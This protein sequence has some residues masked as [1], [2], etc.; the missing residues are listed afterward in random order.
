MKKLFFILVLF[1]ALTVDAA[2]YYVKVGGVDA[3]T[4]LSDAQAWSFTKLATFVPA[5]GDVIL[6]RR[7]DTFSGTLTLA[8]SATS[9]SPVTYGAYGSGAA[10][11]LSGFKTITGWTLYSTGIYRSATVIPT[12]C[13][14]V[15]INGT[16]TA[17]G[18]YPQNGF[19]TFESFTG[20]TS[21]VDNQLT[22]TPNFTG[23]EVVI[24]KS[25]W[26]IDRSPITSH[27]GTTV[28]YT[29]GS[30]YNPT[31]TGEYQYFFQKSIN[32][33]LKFGDWF[34]D[35]AYFYMFFGANNPASYVVKA[36]FEDKVIQSTS[37]H[38]NTVR[39]LVIE[40]G[41]TAGLYLTFSNGFKLINTTVKSI[42]LYGLW[43]SSSTTSLVDSCSFTDCNGWGANIQADGGVVRHST[44]NNI[45]LNFG[46]SATT[47][48]GH[49]A[50]YHKGVN[51]ITEYNVITN[52]GYIPL[53]FFGNGHQVRYNKVD[54]YALLGQHDGGGIY[55]YFG[56][57]G[58]YQSG[59][60]V[61]NNTVANSAA[62]GLYADN[63]SNNQ[64]WYN[65]VVVNITKWG[66][67]MNMPINNQIHN[68]VF[69]NCELAAIDV[70]NLA[71]QT[72]PASGTV[73][74]NN[75]IIQGNAAQ[76]IGSFN[77]DRTNQTKTVPFGT[78][79]QNTLIIDSLATNLY[80][81]RYVLPSYHTDSY[82][83][84]SWRTFSG[85]E[86]NS[87]IRLADV[88]ELIFLYNDTKTA[89]SFAITGAK[90]ELT[91]TVYQTTVTV[92]PFASILLFPHTLPP[93][94]VA[95]TKP[96][97]FGGQPL[98]LFNKMAAMP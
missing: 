56:V 92:Q 33:L 42:G 73:I 11:V 93:V 63:L 9:T 79:N 28:S 45:G 19:L 43:I 16:N 30:S 62:N 6:F 75:L 32:C 18:K 46:M 31:G 98:K 86:V 15:T 96:L 58:S 65:N 57:E 82:T 41:N 29:S 67:H 94:V 3:N 83:L 2:T 74:Q 78:S 34:T 61:Y 68:N 12:S 87:T 84:A 14:V 52:V 53:N 13:D 95:G 72:T 50:L 26:M 55:T 38:Y 24:R 23:A 88:A 81:N 85:R 51:N 89:K 54:T 22:N 7:G 66:M 59:M 20:R 27:S 1:A 39:D 80:Y 76:K 21:F 10:P 35:G 17:I 64:E 47:G 5:N 8:K 44:F 69:Y 97:R 4:G 60:K 37:K 36:G 48:G 77:D 91:G 49:T 70:S 90:K 25:N 71:A 40:G